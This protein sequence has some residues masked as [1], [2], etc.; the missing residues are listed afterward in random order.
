MLL[1]KNGVIKWC[2]T[3]VTEKTLATTANVNELRPYKDEEKRW[4][5]CVMDT[6]NKK[7]WTT[8]LCQNI[9][10]E[11]LIELGRVN[12]KKI[13]QVQGTLRNKKYDPDLSCD[14]YIYE[15]KGRSWCTSGTAGEKIL[16]VP[17]KYGEI[18]NLYKKPLKII[19]VGYQEYEARHMWQFGDL[20]DR[21][22]QTEELKE[23]LAYHKAH[24]IEYIGFT[25]I[26]KQINYPKYCWK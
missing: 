13:G 10:K 23:V 25:D 8:L 20:L 24:G 3:G 16:G 6:V 15:V 2:Y 4:G 26:L 17:I 12:V 19:L 14:K 9:V 5:N 7:Q 22:N 1:N 11:A 18:P 21:K